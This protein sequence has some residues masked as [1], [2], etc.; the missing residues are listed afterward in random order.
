VTD[1]GLAHLQS[2]TALQQLDLQWCS[3]VTDAGLAHLREYL[4]Q[5][6]IYP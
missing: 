4:L 5:C 3:K 6:R 2:L 1:A